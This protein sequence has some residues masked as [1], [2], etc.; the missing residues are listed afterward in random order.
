MDFLEQTYLTNSFF[1]FISKALI[2]FHVFH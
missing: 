1:T 2:R